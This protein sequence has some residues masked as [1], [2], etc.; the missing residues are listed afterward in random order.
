MSG[1]SKRLRQ[2]L[3]LGLSRNERWKRQR[4]LWGSWQLWGGRHA[5]EFSLCQLVHVAKARAVLGMMCHIPTVE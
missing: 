3:R 4:H 2:N 5:V 1:C